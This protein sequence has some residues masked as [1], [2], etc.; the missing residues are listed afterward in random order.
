MLQRPLTDV[1]KGK[2][3]MDIQIDAAQRDQRGDNDPN[4]WKHTDATKQFQQASCLTCKPACPDT[5]MIEV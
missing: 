4:Y 5:G 1:E 2:A 3:K